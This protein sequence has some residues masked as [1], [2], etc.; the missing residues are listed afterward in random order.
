M[1]WMRQ[2]WDYYT[3][4]TAN[5]IGVRPT[6]AQLFDLVDDTNWSGTSGTFN[7]SHHM[8]SALSGDQRTR[9]IDYKCF[10]GIDKRDC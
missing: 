10:N 2:W 1:D 7:V 4:D 3:N 9:W 6:M 8:E 5:S